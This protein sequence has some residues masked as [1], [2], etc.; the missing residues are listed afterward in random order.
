MS[1]ADYPDRLV[2]EEEREDITSISTS[3]ARRLEKKGLFPKRIRV[4]ERSIRW[5]LSEL[6]LWVDSQQG[7]GE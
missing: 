6:S 3:Q 4:G 1:N 2:K 7:V 5:K